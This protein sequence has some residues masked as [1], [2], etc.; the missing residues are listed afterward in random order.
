VASSQPVNA[1]ALVDFVIAMEGLLAPGHGESRYRFAMQGAYYLAKTPSERHEVF[2][3]L[4]ELY[5]VRSTLV[6]GGPTPDDDTVKRLRK[7][8][9]RFAR[10]G[11][12]KALRSGWPSGEE[13]RRLVLD[14]GA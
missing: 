7:A 6:H 13:L 11:L 5:D 2:T 10:L 3:A 1:E 8:A 12:L 4:R 9:K 14:G